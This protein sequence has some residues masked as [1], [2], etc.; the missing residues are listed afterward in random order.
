[1]TT[2]I[3][4]LPRHERY[5]TLTRRAHWIAAVIII[6]TMI[7]GY[8]LHLMVGTV[9]FAFFSVLNMSLGTLVIPLMIVRYI[10]A[11]FRP[12]VPYPTDLSRPKKNM[13]HL[14]HEMFYLIIFVML[15]SGVL[16]LTHGF[17]LF[18][19][20]DIPQPIINPAVNAF[21]FKIHRVAC[22]A[23]SVTLVLHIA[24]VVKHQL[25]D[26]RDILSRML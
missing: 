15:I 5:D 7:A 17:P 23:V 13:A 26:K 16:M 6:Y 14:A 1:M 21:F 4:T 20:I 12:S 18:W 2:S 24:A 9:Y 8:S 11:F 3:D 10:W 19:L 25:I 22:I